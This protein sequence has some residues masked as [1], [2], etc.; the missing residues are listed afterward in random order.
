MST[1]KYQ[2]YYQ[3]DGA[4]RAQP[5]KEELTQEEITFNI[6]S[7]FSDIDYYFSDGVAALER[8]STN[9]L[10]VT[11]DISEA[12]CDEIVKHC[13]NSLDLYAKKN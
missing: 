9:C 4:T 5:F 8:V 6:E 7:F 3:Y 10:E 2:P 11:T 13:L 1:Y 12:E